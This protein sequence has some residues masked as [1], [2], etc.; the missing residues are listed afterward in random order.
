MQTENRGGVMKTIP[1]FFLL[2][3][4]IM[5]FWNPGPVLCAVS[6]TKPAKAA[7]NLSKEKDI[8]RILVVLDS[9]V[10]DRKLRKKATDK[11]ATMNHEKLQ[12]IS[13]LCDKVEI[14]GTSARSDI[15]F[16]LVSLMIILS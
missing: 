16:S 7:L 2:L 13:S 3:G 5:L 8:S 6:D 9:R 4:M 15:A 11:L 10:D 1:A 14:N 12:L